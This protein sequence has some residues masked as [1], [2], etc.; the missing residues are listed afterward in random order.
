MMALFGFGKKKESVN[1]S[2]CS[3]Q[4]GCSISQ[5]EETSPAQTCAC[6]SDGIAIQVLGTGC[7]SCHALLEHTQEAVRHMGLDAN[8]EYIQDMVRI[9]S[10]GVMSVPALVVNGMVASTGK[11]LKSTEVEAILRQKLQ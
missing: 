7:A 9:A 2:A 4:C 3:C 8:V 11:V 10:Y 6:N 1:P 5:A